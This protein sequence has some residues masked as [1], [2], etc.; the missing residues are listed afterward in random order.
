MPFHPSLAPL[1]EGTVV[2]RGTIYP[3]WFSLF[4]DG[5]PPAREPQP[6]VSTPGVPLLLPLRHLSGL[7]LSSRSP[8]SRPSSPPSSQVWLLREA[9][10]GPTLFLMGPL[11]FFDRSS[12]THHGPRSCIIQTGMPSNVVGTW[13]RVVLMAISYMTTTMTTICI[14]IITVISRSHPKENI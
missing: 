5:G 14:T 1:R 2:G 8:S 13:K 10:D 12:S 6:V 3:P 7:F 11:L 4:L 9:P